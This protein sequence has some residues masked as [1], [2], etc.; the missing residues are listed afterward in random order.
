MAGGDSPW[1]EILPGW[2]QGLFA[3]QP[4]NVYRSRT[5]EPAQ[6]L[7]AIT[8]AQ[9]PR[10]GDYYVEITHGSFLHRSPKLEVEK[11][12]IP[13]VVGQGE[14]VVQL[15]TK[16]A[17]Q[18]AFSLSL[19]LRCLEL[20][21]REGQS[22]AFLDWFGLEPG[23]A[24]EDDA[25][26]Q[27]AVG[28]GKQQGVPRLQ[29]AIQCEAS[30]EPAPLPRATWSG[31]STAASSTMGGQRKPP[32]VADQEDLLDQHVAWYL[33]HHESVHAQH[34]VV[35]KMPGVYVI[36]GR[37]V[38]VEW[39]HGR[40][41]GQKECLMVVDGPLRQ[42]FA[43]YMQGSE[44]DCDYTRECPV[45]TSALN[46]LPPEKRISFP[47]EGK[48]SDRLEAMR[49]AK[50]Q[51][52]AREKAAQQAVDSRGRAGSVGSAG[53]GGSSRWGGGSQRSGYP[54]SQPVRSLW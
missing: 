50:Q 54:S 4:C 8:A 28:R 31:A 30:H 53:S 27:R 48:V 16:R 2:L 12:R 13:I 24:R 38:R 7:F 1:A 21:Q 20:G 23:P 10:A 33:K 17:S 22:K 45:T 29:I 46:S 42:P 14:L 11:L 18:P 35:R 40:G 51:A 5:G 41:P 52:S 6:L 44:D 34:Y 26:F 32:Y 36:D 9:V 19:P 37:E 43:H 39:Q 3:P 47:S 15:C 25:A 49:I